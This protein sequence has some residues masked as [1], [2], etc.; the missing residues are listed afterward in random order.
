[1]KKQN[2][3]QMKRRVN[4]RNHWRMRQKTE[5]QRI[6]RVAFRQQIVAYSPLVSMLLLAF[7]AGW[8]VLRDVLGGGA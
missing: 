4:R 1:M 2:D 8:L 6:T 5:A 3:S 7:I